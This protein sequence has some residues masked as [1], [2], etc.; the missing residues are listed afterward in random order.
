[1]FLWVCVLCVCVSRVRV[2]WVVSLS[3][4]VSASARVFVECQYHCMSTRVFAHVR[5]RAYLL[6]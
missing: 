5:V 1:M 3:V 6:I 2:I 4:S